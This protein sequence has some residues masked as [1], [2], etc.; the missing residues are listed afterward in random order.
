MKTFTL[1]ESEREEVLKGLNKNASLSETAKNFILLQLNGD[2]RD[3]DVIVSTITS[4][5]NN[6]LAGLKSLW[7]EA[8]VQLDKLDIDIAEIEVPTDFIEAMN[9]R[10]AVVYG[11]YLEKIEREQKQGDKHK[12]PMS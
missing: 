5:L 6:D 4:I 9:A 11:E 3:V 12:H 7:Y 10:L 8:G 1:S 2:M